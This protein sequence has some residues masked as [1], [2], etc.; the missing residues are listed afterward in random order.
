[1][2]AISDVPLVAQSFFGGIFAFFDYLFVL[3]LV[4]NLLENMVF[5]ILAINQAGM[6]VKSKIGLFKFN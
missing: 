4:V 3:V 5:G 2:M 6:T 1:M